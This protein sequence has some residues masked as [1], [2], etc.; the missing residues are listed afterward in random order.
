MSDRTMDDP[1]KRPGLWTRHANGLGRRS[2]PWAVFAAASAAVLTL[3]VLQYRWLGE[4][5]RSTALARRAVLT[6]VLDVVSKEAFSELKASA[7]PAFGVGVADLSDEGLEKLGA[8]LDGGRSEG[9]RRVF[10]YSLRATHPLHYFDPARR[11]FVVPDYSDET[12]AVW[13]AVA[14]WTLLAKK[15]VPA[16]DHRVHS[17]ERDPRHRILLRVIPD[18]GSQ[19]VGVAG[20][21]VDD[22][23]FARSALP[24]AT[25]STLSS[26][27]EGSALAVFVANEWGEPVLPDAPRAPK[28][29]WTVAR[30]LMPPFSDWTIAV[31]D[32]RSTPER[33]ARRNYALNMTLSLVLGSLLLGAVLLT[34]RT[35]AREMRLSAMKSDFVSNVSHE[36]RTPL[37]SIRV[38]GEL[39]RTGRVAGPEKVVEYGERIETEAVR[40]GLLVENILDFS[41]IEAGRKVYRFEDGDLAPIVRATVATCAARA[42]A[43]GFRIEIEHLDDDLPT[44]RLDG[45]AIE[46]ALGNLLEN[47]VKYSGE[48]RE[49]G[50]GV[51]RRGREV[52]VTV[53]DRGIGIPRGEQERIFERFHRVGGSLVHDVRGVGLGLAIVRHIVDAHHGRVE[54]ESEPG[55]GSTFSIVLPVARGGDGAS[56]PAVAG[57][58]A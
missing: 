45:P 44:L 19:I 10:V 37:A 35:A 36:L 27:A 21:V 41:R 38:F 50:V 58:P 18:A 56:R 54:V 14:P 24:K 49:I 6:K 42:R 33:L 15:G 40:L 51:A 20:V 26:F 48:S 23:Y 43:A 32:Q 30:R 3:A 16:D 55:R 34:T 25:R 11:A 22:A 17:D 53:R 13:S 4:L 12:L 7:E 52:A 28:E 5:E 47:A 46:Q 8:R 2:A 29:Q 9:V 39:M 57:T 1:T 31:Q